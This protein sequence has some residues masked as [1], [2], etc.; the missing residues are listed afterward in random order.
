MHEQLDLV[1]LGSVM[2][3]VSDGDEVVGRHK[4][5]RCQRTALACMHKGHHLC[6]STFNFLHGIGKHQVP[7]IT[8]SFLEYVTRF[9]K[10]RHNGAFLEIQI[11]SS[12]G[13]IYLKLCSVA[14]P[15]L[16]CK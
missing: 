10:T 4:P 12:V 2:S 15:M 13:F 5:A 9:A 7:A 8:K 14:I 11:I 6:R 16:Y 3:R 1:L